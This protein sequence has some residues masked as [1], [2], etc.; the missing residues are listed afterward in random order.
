MME[1]GWDAIF[2]S[3]ANPQDNAFTMWLGTRLPAVGSAIKC[4]PAYS[5]CAKG[6]IGN[7]GCK[8]ARAAKRSMSCL[9]APRKASRSKAR[10]SDSDSSQRRTEDRRSRRRVEESR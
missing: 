3:H 4:R 6:R 7:L 1:T 10:Q 5:D 8:A 9:L 2:I